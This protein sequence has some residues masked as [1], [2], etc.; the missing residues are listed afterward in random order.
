MLEC[1]GFRLRHGTIQT[2]RQSESCSVEV[3]IP[4]MSDAERS[5]QV[6]GNH[7]KDHAIQPWDIILEYKLDFW[8]G[9]ALKYILRK[10]LDRL[11][12]LKKA[13]HYL[14]EAIRQKE[15]CH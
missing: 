6:G 8:E 13:R 14:D 12:D 4:R 3:K 10:K 5:K 15:A 1:E 2:L 9:N 7:Y 11:E